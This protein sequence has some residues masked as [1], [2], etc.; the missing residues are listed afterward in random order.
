MKLLY[1]K[2]PHRPATDL[3]EVIE[4]QVELQSFADHDAGFRQYCEQY[5]RAVANPEVR[6][7]YQRWVNE[8]MRQHGMIQSAE[9]RGE[10]RG[11]K[12]GITTGREQVLELLEQGYS[13]Q[14]IREILDAGEQEPNPKPTQ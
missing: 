14:Q 8:Q 6:D 9:E 7:E 12:R 4:M 10:K 2:P 1:V 11:E 5:D 13:P 3:L